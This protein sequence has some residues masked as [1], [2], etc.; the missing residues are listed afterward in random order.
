[1]LHNTYDTAEILCLAISETFILNVSGSLSI[2]NP[3]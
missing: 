2:L 1:M 3:I